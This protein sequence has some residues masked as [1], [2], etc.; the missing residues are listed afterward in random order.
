MIKA[1]SIAALLGACTS[2]EVPDEDFTDLAGQDAKSDAFSTKLRLLGSIEPDQTIASLAYTH[3]P[4]FR[5]LVFMANAQDSIRLEV[6]STSDGGDPIAWLLS[7]DFKTLAKNDDADSSTMDSAIE[8]VVPATTNPI[9]YIVWKDVTEQDAT[10]QVSYANSN[11]A[12][13]CTDS[14]SPASGTLS[15]FFTIALTS[16]HAVECEVQLDNNPRVSAPCNYSNGADG[17][18][19]G[20]GS[21]VHTPSVDTQN[22]PVVD[23]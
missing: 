11:A 3:N 2:R 6:R 5:G 16:Q 23:T 17:S 20:V 7:S 19:F 15:T 22:R 12:P 4:P 8:L 21:H 9:H 14:I 13:T 1:I 10:F 18:L